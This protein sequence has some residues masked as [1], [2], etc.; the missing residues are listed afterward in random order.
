MWFASGGTNGTGGGFTVPNVPTTNPAN[1][2]FGQVL[3]QGLGWVL[4]IMGFVIIALGIWRFVQVLITHYRGKD[5]GYK[6][7]ILGSG[8]T[9]MPPVVSAGLDILGGIV[10]AGIF[11]NGD[12]VSIVNG[13]LHIGANAGNTIGSHLQNTP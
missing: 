5:L 2:A 6:H 9:Q 10:L 1:T 13:L 12:W 3:I 7:G 4:G 8:I 11:L